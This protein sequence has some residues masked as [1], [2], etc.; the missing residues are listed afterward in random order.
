M[1]QTIV[2]AG[3]ASLEKENQHWKSYWEKEGCEILAWPHPIAPERL[4]QDYPDVH[5]HFFSSI[6]TADLFFLMNADKKGI[7]GYIG[8]ESFAELAY[9]VTR[10]LLHGQ[11]IEILLLQM[12]SPQVQCH[13]EISLWLKLGWIKVYQ[14]QKT[15][16]P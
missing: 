1:S 15:T 13:D 2:I 12:T 9:A 14:P 3:S 6:E 10:R 7:N 16:T 5:R 8:A 11:K 4:E